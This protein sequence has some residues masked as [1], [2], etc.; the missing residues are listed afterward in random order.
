MLVS[1]TFAADNSVIRQKQ[2]AGL[3]ALNPKNDGVDCVAA[4]GEKGCDLEAVLALADQRMYE[5]KR[6]K[7]A[8]NETQQ[9]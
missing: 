2:E 3:A 9:R 8:R 6:V 7:K 4:C 5:D 1:S